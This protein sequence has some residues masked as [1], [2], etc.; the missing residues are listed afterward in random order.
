[1]SCDEAALL[2]ELATPH[3]ASAAFW[4]FLERGR[5]ALPWAI[6]GLSDTRAD[7]RWHC[8]RLLDHLVTPDGLGALM[9]MLDDPDPRV[10]GA[11]LHSLTCDRCKDGVCLP[12]DG[13]LLERAI[14]MMAKDSNGHV[15]AAAVG[16]VGRSVHTA[17]AAAAALVETARSDPSPTVRK[18]ARW[19]AP[20]GPLF[21]RTRRA[22]ELR[23]RKAER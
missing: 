1:M 3:K 20:G 8:C 18:V 4:R 6:R 7:V 5:A 21:E 10:R 2:D 11:A 15:R 14:G 17:P 22:A 19:H 9:D 13:P 12:T 16:A 23:R